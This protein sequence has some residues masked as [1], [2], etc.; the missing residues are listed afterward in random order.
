MPQVLDR[1]L[2]PDE[3]LSLRGDF[4]SHMHWYR[5]FNRPYYASLHY[6]VGSTGLASRAAEAAGS[7]LDQLRRVALI[8]VPEDGCIPV[9]RAD[10]PPL[11]MVEALV[12]RPEA[13][14]VWTYYDGKGFTSVG[15]EG[16]QAV[17]YDST[18]RWGLTDV[19]QGRW[20]SIQFGFAL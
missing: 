4:V 17:V 20:W 7:T 5:P 19:A 6:R 10:D 18:T 12:G 1:F 11:R 2:R 13:G 16:R 8:D 3:A 14:G 9:H 15:L